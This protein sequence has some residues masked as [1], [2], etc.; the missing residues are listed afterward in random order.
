MRLADEADMSYTLVARNILEK[1]LEKNDSDSETGMKTSDVLKSCMKDPSLIKN[2]DLAY[3]IY[4]CCLY[5]DQYGNITE[6]MRQYVSFLH[7]KKK[8]TLLTINFFSSLGQE[9]EYYL[10]EIVKKNNLSFQSEDDLRVYGYDKTPDIKLNIPFAVDGFV[11]N[12]I[13]SKALFADPEV[14]RGY[15]KDQYSSYWNRFGTGLVIYWLGMVDAI[16][17]PSEKRFIVR[18]NFPTNLTVMNPLSIAAIPNEKQE[19]T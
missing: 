10:Q 7:N 8:L 14:H 5:D 17:D 15:I 4:L 3:E 12:W 18:C 13:E 6:V 19:K 16:I 2:P 9:Y 1:W 11:I